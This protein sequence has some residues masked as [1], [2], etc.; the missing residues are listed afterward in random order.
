MRLRIVPWFTDD[1]IVFLNNLFK[2]YPQ[3][4]KKR[5]SMLEFGGGNSTVY[6]LQRG[7]SVVTVES[8]DV[9]IRDLVD[10]AKTI[11]ISCCV[12][13]SMPEYI[14]H[15]QDY[16]LI[17]FKATEYEAI[18]ELILS[19]KWS[20]ITNDGITRANIL[21]DVYLKTEESII[22]LDNIEYCA[23][24]GRL[25]KCSGKKKQS[26]LYREFL[27]DKNWAKYIFEQKEGRNGHCIAD[28]TGFE[29]PHRWITGIFWK[30]THILSKYIISHQGLPVV[31]ELGINNLDL[32]DLEDRCPYNF[33]ENRWEIEGYPDTLDLKLP[34]EYF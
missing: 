21:Q 29:S 2:W 13:D 28:F 17:I 5:L 18:K 30:N 25:E 9:Y 20:I 10:L 27:R 22:I 7:C 1:S 11:D 31:N 8:E 16:D 26:E 33:E 24:W 3:T 23:N 14:K 4:L 32:D 34:R 6:F 15:S 19:K 12:V